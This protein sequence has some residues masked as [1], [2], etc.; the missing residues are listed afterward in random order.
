MKIE[1]DDPQAFR[2]LVAVALEQ[3]RKDEA[4]AQAACDRAMA[5]RARHP[6][7][8]SRARVTTLNA[9]WGRA[10]EHRDR[11]QAARVLAEELLTRSHDL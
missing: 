4:K 9:R 6:P 8:T 1:I 7:G 11:V 3:L 10:A 5:A 2:H